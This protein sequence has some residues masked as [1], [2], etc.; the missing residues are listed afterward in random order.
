MRRLAISAL[1]ASS[2]SANRNNSRTRRLQ[3]RTLAL[4]ARI[5]AVCRP[6]FLALL[7][8]GW[9]PGFRR[10]ANDSIGLVVFR[11]L[12]TPLPLGGTPKVAFDDEA[13]G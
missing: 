5:W 1:S 11:N 6:F 4:K 13:L 7:L 9:P 12:E 10:G 3:A 2:A 8:P